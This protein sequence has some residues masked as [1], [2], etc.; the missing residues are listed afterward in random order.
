MYTCTLFQRVNWNYM[1][2]G[3]KWPI[4]RRSCSR[5]KVVLWNVENVKTTINLLT[6]MTN[7]TSL[8]MRTDVK[9]R[10]FSPLTLFI[11]PNRK[12]SVFCIFCLSDPRLFV[13]YSRF[14]TV[15]CFIRIVN[16][17]FYPEKFTVTSTY[18]LQ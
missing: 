4:G 8:T 12:D 7:F 1:R 15:K 18:L 6:L 2:L 17:T 5:Y 14:L 13:L 9:L 3:I 16:F 11:L 10:V